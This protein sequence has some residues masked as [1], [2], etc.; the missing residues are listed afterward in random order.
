M[1][2]S[3]SSSITESHQ[4]PKSVTAS[5]KRV[6]LICFVVG[7]IIG[8]LLSVLVFFLVKNRNINN[9]PNIVNIPKETQR[10]PTAAY[11]IT[12]TNEPVEP[13][14]LAKPVKVYPSYD[15][16]YFAVAQNTGGQQCAI[17]IEDP[18]G[19]NYGVP[20]PYLAIGCDSS[21]GSLITYTYLGWVGNSKLA[22]EQKA[23]KLQIFDL[24]V[25]GSHDEQDYSYDT[26]KWAL[27]GVSSN[28]D[29]LLLKNIQSKDAT[30]LALFNLNDNQPVKELNNLP[31]IDVS[32]YYDHVNNGFLLYWLEAKSNG[33]QELSRYVFKYIYLS[34]LTV[35]DVFTTDYVASKLGRSCS[36][37]SI[38]AN[39]G[40]LVFG[41]C[42][43]S[44]HIKI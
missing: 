40:D 16:S 4:E 12:P 33:S 15:G 13:Y 22:L 20:G 32:T 19:S 2:S 9:S 31:N 30:N 7:L 14:Y 29:Y 18:A 34:D 5:S 27:L 10:T 36:N 28:A 44:A 42:F 39:K 38:T 23:G 37:D 43:G 41:G 3:D 21:E 24:A 35:K 6:K 25:A 17:T 1:E 26:D 8:V 11:T